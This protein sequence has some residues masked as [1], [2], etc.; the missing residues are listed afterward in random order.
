MG[1]ITLIDFQ[2]ELKIREFGDWKSNKFFFNTEKNLLLQYEVIKADKIYIWDINTGIQINELIVDMNFKN[3]NFIKGTQDLVKISYKNR[4]EIW[5]FKENK[6]VIDFDKKN[7][8]ITGSNM[9][10]SILNDK[11]LCI[12]NRLDLDTIFKYSNVLNFD[13]N[14]KGNILGIV[15]QEGS[16]NVASIIDLLEGNLQEIILNDKKNEPKKITFLKNNKSIYVHVEK[17]S[18]SFKS[19]NQF[20]VFKFNNKIS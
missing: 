2:S 15:W 19:Y 18:G 17:S 13:S 5:N 6:K 8:Y 14:E 7:K 1:K 12:L 20:E 16:K 11:E 9:H 4:T 3:A 10:L